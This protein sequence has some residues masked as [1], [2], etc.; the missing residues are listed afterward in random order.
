MIE[1]AIFSNELIHQLDLNGYLITKHSPKEQRISLPSIPFR[2]PSQTLRTLG[3][4][5][6]RNECR[7]CLHMLEYECKSYPGRT[8]RDSRRLQERIKL[9]TSTK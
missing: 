5:R 8:D 6:R 7:C 9:F 2:W 3:N 4:F 1:K